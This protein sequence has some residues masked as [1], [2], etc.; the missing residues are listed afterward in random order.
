MS[1]TI[2]FLGLLAFISLACAYKSQTE[3]KVDYVILYKNN[4]VSKKW[5]TY[6]HRH[7]SKRAENRKITLNELAEGAIIIHVAVDDK[8]SHDYCITKDD[9]EIGIT[10]KD[11]RIML[12]LVYQLISNLSLNDSG[13][14]ASDID[15][16][17]VS[18][19]NIC[20]DFDFSYREP[21]FSPNLQFEHAPIIGTDMVETSWG[22]WGHGI[23]KIL[24]SEP[25]STVYAENKGKIDKTQYCFSST[26]L[27]RLTK[28]YIINNFGDGKEQS[29]KFMLMPN[30]NKVVCTCKKCVALGNTN[31]NATPAVS[32]F[33]SKLAKCYPKHT[34]FT[35]AY[36]TTETPP[37]KPM[38]SNTGVV[39]STINLP[40]GV[41][42][43][44]SKELDKFTH[45]VNLW[46][47]KIS[48]IYIWDYAANFDDWMTPLPVLYAFQKQ[49]S[50]FQK[51]GVK[52]VFLNGS[53]YDY[54]PFDDV[55]TY[56]SAALMMDVNTSVDSLC[57]RYF[58]HFYPVS[59]KY[60][61]DYYLYL[62]QSLEKVNKP[63][64]IYGSFD[65]S[66]LFADTDKFVCFYDSI[67]P[68]I[69]RALGEEKIKLQKLQTALSFP[70]LQLAVSKGISVHGFA[71]LDKCKMVPHAEIGLYIKRLKRYNEF[72]DMNNYK[73]VNGALDNFL[74]HIESQYIN[75]LSNLL[76]G[77][78]IK[79]LSKLDDDYSDVTILQDGMLGS[80]NDYH[81]GWMQMSAGSCKF[82]IEVTQNLKNTKDLNLR[83]LNDPRHNILPPSAILIYKNGKKYMELF[84]KVDGN[85]D[86]VRLST[87]LKL[88][89]A[90]SLIIEFIKQAKNNTTMA[91]DEIVIN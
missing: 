29:S 31:T 13:I 76:I 51:Q 64:D 38:P 42:L 49:L 80:E 50:F 33:I 71:K 18:I 46:K 61:S 44:H 3:R 57:S 90:Q 41:A 22:I 27:Y 2:L 78:S 45:L 20:R 75:P 52:G 16:P 89:D 87:E 7:L 15:P 24:E 1:K 88:L 10:A 4:S 81:H 66:I 84:P 30:D 47:S 53:G 91:C 43:Q 17:I 73:E 14:D 12:W 86:V 70:R 63:Y 74:K 35:T 9:K 56:V 21:Y 77:A 83:F 62:E 60:L 25:E 28:L 23:D 72:E 67:E 54:S 5:A 32:H 8:N 85:L 59:G 19:G 36:L 11:E 55:K 40:K 34:F 69:T 82:A 6:L 37:Q 26:E 65:R 79:S 39:I 58:T 48:N 68:L